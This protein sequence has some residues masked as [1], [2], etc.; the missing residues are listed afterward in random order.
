[1]INQLRGG[2]ALMLNNEN[3]AYAVFIYSNDFGLRIADFGL[4]NYLI[5]KHL[6][7]RF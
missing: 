5:L 7:V 6:A 3:Q 1:M 2:Y 4:R